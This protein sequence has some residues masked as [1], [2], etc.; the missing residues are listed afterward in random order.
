[1]GCVSRKMGEGAMKIRVRWLTVPIRAKGIARQRWVGRLACEQP[2]PA[3]P[4]PPPP[5]HLQHDYTI[6]LLQN[7]PAFASTLTPPPKVDIEPT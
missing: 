7:A 2:P 6:K 1:M 4:P 5:R 3:P